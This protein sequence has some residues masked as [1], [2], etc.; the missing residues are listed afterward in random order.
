ATASGTGRARYGDKEVQDV[1]LSGQTPN[2]GDIDTRSVVEGRYFTPAEAAHRAGVC[3]VGDT[4]VQRLFP[5]ANPIGKT[6]RVGTEELIIVGVMEK[7]GSVLGQDQDNFV[8]VPL[9][10][11]LRMQG[12]QTSLTINVKTIPE[13]FQ[14]AQDEAQLIM[15]ARRHLTGKAEN[16]FFIGTKESYMALWRTISSAFFGV[17]ILVSVISVVIGGIVIMHVMLVS[18]TARRQAL[19]WSPA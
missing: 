2:M 6:I 19:G 3:L 13:N 12:P 15:R 4:I 16:D 18:V 10:V 8:M 5:G 1:S 14:D 9:P 17:F 11:F 7:V